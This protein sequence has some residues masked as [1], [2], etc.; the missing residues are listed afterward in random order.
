MQQYFNSESI[1]SLAK[2]IRSGC[3]RKHQFG[4]NATAAWH[5]KTAGFVWR[6]NRRRPSCFHKCLLVRNKQRAAT[7][8]AVSA[9]FTM[10][11]TAALWHCEVVF[12]LAVDRRRQQA[13]AGPRR[14]RASE[15][16]AGGACNWA[17]CSI[18]SAAARANETPGVSDVQRRSPN[19]TL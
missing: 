19:S 2:D 5:G 11:C 4:H 10:L 8:S 16:L 7:C 9:A 3:Y 15:G 17:R 18:F 6:L 13:G 1:C 12:L 14:N